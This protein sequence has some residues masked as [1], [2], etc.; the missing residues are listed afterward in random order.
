M[1]ASPDIARG[2][3]LFALAA[4]LSGSTGSWLNKLAGA[5]QIVAAILCGGTM[6]DRE[7]IEGLENGTEPTI[8]Q[9]LGALLRGRMPKP[10]YRTDR[11]QEPG[12][13]EKDKKEDGRA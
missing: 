7:Y 6:L 2:I 11:Q 13:S 5:L 4:C 1:C 10:P 12:I 3:E 9:V 8:G